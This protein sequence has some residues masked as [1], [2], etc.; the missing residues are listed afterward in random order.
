MKKNNQIFN[1]AKKIINY[2]RSLSGKGVRETL[3]E[4]K[5]I[6]PNLSI[7]SF[8]SGK[9]VFD[10]KIPL[11]WEV[12]NAFIITPSGKKICNYDDNK[13]HLIGYSTPIKKVLSKKQIIKKL[14]SLPNLKTAI[15]YIT[16]YYKKDWGF[17]ISHQEKEKLKD[18]NYQVIINTKFKKGVVNYGELFIKG[19][20]K[21][22]ILF[23]T[24]ICHPEMANN[25]VS[26]ISVLTYLA[27]WIKSRKRKFSYRIIFIPETIG[28]IAY[29]Q[30]NL[31][32]LKRN[33]VAG[34]VITCV[35]DTKNFSYI[36]SRY[37]NTLSDFAALDVLK[38]NKRKFKIYTWLDRGSDERQFCAPNIN[39]PFCSITRSKYGTYKEYHTS[40]DKLGS[41]VVSKGLNGSYKLFKNYIKYFEDNYVNSFYVPKNNCYCE[42][43]L[44]KRNLYP[45]ISNLKTAS[46]VKSMMN[47]L[48]YVDGKNSVMQIANLCHLSIINVKKY[49]SIFK[50]HKLIK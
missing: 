19:E 4:I 30:K 14:Y 16:S 36:P 31:K 20:T 50:K 41:V 7:K 47:V 2:P 3:K 42:P 48:S 18:G 9:K 29:I 26:G 22:E 5:K 15:P 49:L 13:L 23:S 46:K 6:V 27:K 37:G 1:F 24:Y 45:T 12:K 38:K 10:W 32:R 40:L 8:K 21:R 33:L 35:G 17:C 25:E 28:S 39:L 43:H 44:S 11:E 34:L